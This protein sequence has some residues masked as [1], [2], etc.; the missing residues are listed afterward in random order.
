MK[1]EFDRLSKM[2][3]ASAF[4]AVKVSDIVKLINESVSL[5]IQ[6]NCYCILFDM[7]KAEEI[8][9]FMDEYELNKDLT[10]LTDLTHSHRC[11]VVYHPNNQKSESQLKFK[12]TVADNWGQGIFKIFFDIEEGIEWLT[13]HNKK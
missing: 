4:G 9:G 8:Y 12:E 2:V 10:K 1:I 5:G 3:I 7:T 6:Y 11:A 13:T